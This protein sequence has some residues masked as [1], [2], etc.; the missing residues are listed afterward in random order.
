LFSR[1]YNH[2]SASRNKGAL[3]ET[4]KKLVESTGKL[5][6]DIEHSIEQIRIFTEADP[7]QTT[8]D[9]RKHIEEVRLQNASLRLERMA[10]E[11]VYGHLLHK[12]RQTERQ[13]PVISADEIA[14]ERDLSS[15]LEELSE[16]KPKPRGKHWAG[17][18]SAALAKNP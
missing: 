17:L 7:Q 15:I 9:L 10:K 2:N 8:R 12:T 13:L 11:V 5:D 3:I 1:F 6:G 18:Y 16:Q 14:R 4:I